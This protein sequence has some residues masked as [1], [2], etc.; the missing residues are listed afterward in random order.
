M[1]IDDVSA[2]VVFNVGPDDTQEIELLLVGHPFTEQP[3]VMI[4]STTNEL[5]IQ[6][7]IVLKEVYFIQTHEIVS[8]LE[9][10]EVK[11]V[12]NV[13]NKYKDL[14]ARNLRQIGCINLAQM[15]LILKDVQ[16]V[17]Y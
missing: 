10:D 16:Q 14:V 9:A 4:I 1:C 12:P 17:V 7:T 11:K 5:K 2:F 8:D 15:K 6:R 3:H 13:L